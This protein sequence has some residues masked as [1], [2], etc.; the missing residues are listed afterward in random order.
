MEHRDEVAVHPYSRIC[1]VPWK[2]VSRF[3]SSWISPHSIIDETD[4]VMLSNNSLEKRLPNLR[5]M[6]GKEIAD[7][8][9]YLAHFL[10]RAQNVN[11]IPESTKSIVL[12]KFGLR[13]LADK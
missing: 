9:I 4:I 5:N 7:K 1:P 8:N 2:R 3:G 11:Y 12:G 6:T 13:R 10:R